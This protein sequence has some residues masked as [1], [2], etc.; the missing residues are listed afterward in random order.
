M[1]HEHIAIHYADN[2]LCLVGS[3]QRPE[4]AAAAGEQVQPVDFEL[5]IVE[6]AQGAALLSMLDIDKFSNGLHRYNRIDH[7]KDIQRS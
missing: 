3:A 2:P 7:R 6:P 4:V 5:L 1:D